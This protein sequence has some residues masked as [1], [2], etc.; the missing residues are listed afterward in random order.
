MSGKAFW[1]TNLLIYWLEKPKA[2]AEQVGALREWHAKQNLEIVT[3]SLSLAEILVQP[4]SKKNIELGRRYQGLISAMGCLPFGAAEAWAFAE[5]RSRYQKL[6]PPDCIQLA[7]A[8]V[9][10][11]DYFFTNDDRLSKVRVDGIHT[12][13]SLSQ[14]HTRQS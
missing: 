11:V 13:T 6:K 2:L 3:S 4:L 14:W 1:D 9:H 8:K 10:G 5:I 7:C 12:I